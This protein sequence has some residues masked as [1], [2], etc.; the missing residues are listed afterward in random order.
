MVT[1]VVLAHGQAGQLPGA[2]RG[3][4]LHANVFMLCIYGM[5]FNV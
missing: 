1:K 5:F 4:G 2:Q 3:Q